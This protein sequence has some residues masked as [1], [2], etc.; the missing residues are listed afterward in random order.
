M[1]P[2]LR[3][4]QS[5]SLV[6]PQQPAALSTRP[7]IAARG[8]SSG[9]AVRSAPRLAVPPPAAAARCCLPPL[10]PGWLRSTP[11]ELQLGAH[12]RAAH[13]RRPRARWV[14]GVAVG[15]DEE[16]QDGGPRAAG[17]P[18]W[19]RQEAS[20]EAGG[21]PW[22]GG[23]RPAQ[24]P[25]GES[26]R[27]G[28]LCQKARRSPSALRLPPPPPQQQHLRD[29]LSPPRPPPPSLP[30]GTASGMSVLDIDTAGMYRPRT[31]ETREAYEALLSVIRE[32]FGDQP[33][34]I[35]RG[36]ADEVLSTLKN[37][38]INVG[39]ARGWVGGAGGAGRR[40][41]M[42]A[43]QGSAADGAG[44]ARRGSAH[45]RLPPS[46]PPPPT[47]PHP[48]TSAGPLPPQG[49][50]RAAGGCGRR[51][52]CAAGGAGQADHRLLLARGGGERG[53]ACRRCGGVAVQRCRS[54]HVQC[55]FSRSPAAIN[56]KCFTL[57]LCVWPP[58]NVCAGP[59]R[60]RG[61]GRAG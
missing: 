1:H 40:A 27:R 25:Q 12:G 5:A 36:A 37:D 22:G 13:Q 30:Q 32:Q 34:D 59:G 3:K 52:V 16:Q 51:E 58:P 15:K 17:A 53:R 19:P 42:A 24:A 28:E 38:R 44:H 31:K 54:S 11:A 50:G 61:R 41:G 9:G 18:R 20:Q 26:K 21:C 43:C 57:I 29:S 56:E 8:V 46:C 39:A 33:A 35:L 49:G 4:P 6:A 7:S 55:F 14:G 10:S 48:P 47:H 60:R 2:A 45:A 23:L